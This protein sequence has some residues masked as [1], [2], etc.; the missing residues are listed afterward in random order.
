M[1]GRSSFVEVVKER[2]RGGEIGIEV[3][4][5]EGEGWGEVDPLILFRRKEITSTIKISECFV[6]AS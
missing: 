6:T 1:T 4:G 5:G 3:G 2:W